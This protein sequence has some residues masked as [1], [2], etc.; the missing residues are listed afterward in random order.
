MKCTKMI[1]LPQRGK[2]NDEKLENETIT[3]T[4]ESG[5]LQISSFI[6]VEPF[7]ALDLENYVWEDAV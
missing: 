6:F 5:V 2:G 3:P 1:K 4:S 7:V